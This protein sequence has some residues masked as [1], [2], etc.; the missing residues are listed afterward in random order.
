MLLKQHEFCVKL[1]GYKYVKKKFRMY[2]TT[3]TA[4][5]WSKKDYFVGSWEAA[6]ELWPAGYY[7]RS[8]YTTLRAAQAAIK[9]LGAGKIFHRSE[10]VFCDINEF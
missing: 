8:C 4:R 2:N 5:Y 6:C 7:Y 1:Q 9:K 3:E 10:L